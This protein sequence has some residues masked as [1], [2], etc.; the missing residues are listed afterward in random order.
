MMDLRE[1][2]AIKRLARAIDRLALVEGARLMDLSGVDA[3]E[4][5]LDQSAV[6]LLELT[7]KSIRTMEERQ[8]ND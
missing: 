8:P 6:K 7:E 2:N 5:L 4:S 1:L 3:A